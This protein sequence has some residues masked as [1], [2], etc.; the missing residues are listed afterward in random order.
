MARLL[1]NL[2]GL[3][4]LLGDAARAIALLEE[5]FAMFVDLDLAVDAGYVCSSLAEIRLETR[6]ARG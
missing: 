3:E 4:H 1:N 2:A 6:R 5:A